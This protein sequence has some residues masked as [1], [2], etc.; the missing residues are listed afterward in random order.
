MSKVLGSN[1]VSMIWTNQ[2]W[3]FDI[4]K[5]VPVRKEVTYIQIFTEYWEG[6]PTTKVTS[7]R[8]IK[9]WD[10]ISQ[11]IPAL[12]PQYADISIEKWRS[13]VIDQT[14]WWITMTIRYTYFTSFY[15]ISFWTNTTQSSSPYDFSYSQSSIAVPPMASM[16]IQTSYVA[17][18]SINIQ[19]YIWQDL[20]AQVTATPPMDGWSSSFIWWFT[21]S[22][23]WTDYIDEW[24]NIP[25][26]WDMTI[27]WVSNNY[28][29]I[30]IQM[31]CSNWT[32]FKD[33]NNDNKCGLYRRVGNCN[34]QWNRSGSFDY[35]NIDPYSSSWSSSTITIN[36]AVAPS[37][38][39][40]KWIDIKDPQWNI[41]RVNDQN[42]YVHIDYHD[43]AGLWDIYSYLEE[44]SWYTYYWFSWDTNIWNSTRRWPL[45][46][47]SK[48]KQSLV[49][50][51]VAAWWTAS[52]VNA[53]YWVLRVEWL[54]DSCNT[55][56]PTEKYYY[57]VY[58]WSYQNPY[59]I[60]IDIT[61]WYWTYFTWNSTIYSSSDTKATFVTNAN[62]FCS[63][64]VTCKNYA[65]SAYDY[66]YVNYSGL[67]N[68]CLF[69]T[70]PSTY[71]DYAAK[72]DN[73]K[74]HCIAW[75]NVLI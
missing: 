34:V 56:S 73:S 33:S 5:W 54:D 6:D 2:D 62:D 71:A 16:K 75:A 59:T 74:E 45:Y 31:D 42:T 11:Y 20:F 7:K 48:W 58:W 23:S 26:S 68:K 35:I 51:I 27:Y 10:D 1:I 55:A 69:N 14:T 44:Y 72:Y 67:N 13:Q 37:W 22:S 19:F 24:I 63:F 32:T 52:S 47:Q 43:T 29:R 9:S 65:I 38:Y 25:L 36:K 8:I 49:N 21:Y 30:D 60:F 15:T 40:V 18:A 57:L 39:K 61:S 46:N 4:I 12:P 28:P 53:C 17:W 50:A 3:S 41:T 64:L 66:Q 70:D